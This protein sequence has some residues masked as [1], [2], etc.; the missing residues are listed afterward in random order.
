METESDTRT[1]NRNEDGAKEY[2]KSHIRMHRVVRFASMRLTAPHTRDAG[3]FAICHL[4]LIVT[5]I[6]MCIPPKDT[7]DIREIILG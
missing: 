3:L 7:R 6:S 4:T 1:E 5:N 2:L